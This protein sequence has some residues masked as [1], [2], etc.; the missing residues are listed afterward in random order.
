M[1]QPRRVKLRKK[2]E[3]MVFTQQRATK[4]KHSRKKSRLL[5]RKPSKEQLV[6][7]LLLLGLFGEE[8]QK[9]F[10]KSSKVLGPK[11]IVIGVAFSPFLISFLIS[12]SFFP[13]FLTF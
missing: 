3:E 11:L 9:L 6:F 5:L 10:S 4:E 12:F 7:L 8:R 13:P 2:I 1:P